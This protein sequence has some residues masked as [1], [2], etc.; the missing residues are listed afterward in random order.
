MGVRHSLRRRPDRLGLPLYD[1][2]F[3]DAFGEGGTRRHPHHQN[4]WTTNR[5]PQ[6]RLTERAA[7][8]SPSDPLPHE[9]LSIE[10]ER[11]DAGPRKG[12][13]A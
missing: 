3:G 12:A 7:L 4:R 11:K 10:V 2:F 13:T 1:P 8:G 5:L 9:L 6:R